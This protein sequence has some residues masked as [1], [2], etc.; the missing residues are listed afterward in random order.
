M[1]AGRLA[2]LAQVSALGASARMRTAAGTTRR[3]PD[4]DQGSEPRETANR[5][6]EHSAPRELSLALRFPC[7]RLRCFAA[8]GSG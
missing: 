6:W 8:K 5:E 4:F 2:V 3:P 1:A 7:Q